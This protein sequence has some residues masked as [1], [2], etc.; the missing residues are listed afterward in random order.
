[1]ALNS[2]GVQQEH[3][4]LLQNAETAGGQPGVSGMPQT[5]N[6]TNTNMSQ[7]QSTLNSNA[8]S[9]CGFSGTNRQ[10]GTLGAQNQM[11]T[12][13]QTKTVVGVFDQRQQADYSVA[14]LRQQ[15]FRQEEISIVAK[16]NEGGGANTG[17][18]ND[19]IVDGVATGGAIGGIGG[20]MAAAGALAI[21]GFGPIIA[22]GPIAAALSGAVAGGVAGGLIDFGVP[23]ERGKAYEAQLQQGKVLTIIRTQASRAS[24][25]ANILSQTGAMNVET[26]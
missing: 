7:T 22:L 26:H 11:S 10:Q 5:Q 3:Q 16:G 21:P 1:M 4:A 23:A 18:Q 2:R 6:M 15:G 14:Q 24:Q 13:Q 17:T 19:S 8:G 12:P 25:V 9:A 20:L